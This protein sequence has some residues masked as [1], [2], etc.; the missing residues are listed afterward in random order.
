MIPNIISTL[1]A[2]EN[3]YIIIT[4]DNKIKEVELGLLGLL[5]NIAAA[6]GVVRMPSENDAA[7]EARIWHLTNNIIFAKT[8][9]TQ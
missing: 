9:Y 3:A 1:G 4:A 5:D 6:Y 7:L 2:E 8:D